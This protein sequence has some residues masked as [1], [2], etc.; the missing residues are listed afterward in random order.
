MRWL[1]LLIAILYAQGG[2]PIGQWGVYAYHGFIDQI[3]YAAPYFWFLSREGVCLLDG[4]TG[5]YQEL[6]RARGL[7]YNRPTA[8]YSDPYSGWIW[9]GYAD[10]QIQYGTEPDRLET[11]R[12]IA[13]NPFYTSRAIRDFAA[14]GDTLVIA[15][16]FG[17]VIYHKR[18]RRVLATVSQFPGKTFAQPV[19]RIWWGMGHLW[20]FLEEG[21]YMLPLGRPWI[22]PWE[23]VT[24]DTLLDS[25][26]HFRGWAEIS[27]A[28]VVAHRQRLYR[29]A[30]TG[31]TAYELAA[32]LQGKRVFSLCGWQGGWGIALD[33]TDVFF[34]GNDGTL[35]TMWN[36]GPHVLWMSPDGSHVAMGTS[37]IGGFALSP[38]YALNTD[39]FQRLRASYVTE[40]LPTPEG[41]FFLHQGRGF[42]GAGWGGTITFYPHGA[43]KGIAY[44]LNRLV[45]RSSGGFTQA[46][47][48]GQR[49]WILTNAYIL[50]L[51]P[52]G[53]VDTFSIYNAPFDGIFPDSTGVPTLMG[54]SCIAIDPKGTVWVGKSYGLRNV[55]WFVPGSNRWYSLPRSEE[56]L[57]VHIDNRGYKWFLM[58]GGKIFVID[59]RGLPEDPSGFRTVMLGSEGIPLP[60]LP[61]SIIQALAPDRSG[62][63]WLGTDKGIAVL[64]GD[65]FAG[66]LSVSIPVIENRYLLEE[67]SI[68]SI[69]VD[70]QN[71]KW[72]GTYSGGVYVVSPDGSRQ[73]ATYNTSNSP[74]PS[75]L[76]YRIRAWDLTGEIFI[77]T[78]DGVV[79]YR[80][81]ATSPAEQ[82]DS[83]YIFPN[84]VSRSFEG[85]VGIRGLSE[86]STVR[87]MTI[88]GQ[89]VRYLQSFGGQAVWDLRTVRG[90]KVS[91]GIYLIGAIDR[92]G[93][94]SAVG[95][96]I[97]T[98]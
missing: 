83:L 53:G 79:S 96:I 24:R 18:H 13:A 74:L 64:Y 80:D 82:L 93:Q 14:I 8:L 76:I 16:D 20:A 77:I 33:T 78:S 26:T 73:L 71:R 43:Q 19:R 50:C 46:T 88:D 65:P 25:V 60:G 66:T 30:D 12:D 15:T 51:T 39:A 42:W 1:S 3:G 92:E 7:L 23:R 86:G 68:T 84:P 32:P 81:F 22:G 61:S 56:V 31:W 28:M 27:G 48:D 36:A 98:D 52:T 47:W 29:W 11:L 4:E 58:R 70:G 40:V 2:V 10:G 62:G 35:R 44:E 69:A 49:A 75:N 59:D 37:W 97:V 63:I 94:R 21:L 87:I 90:E 6:S 34:F 89:Q 17:L 85:W 9:L 41:L 55:L 72:I 57:S 54:F 91:P 45:G 67:E 95:K 5:A 38:R